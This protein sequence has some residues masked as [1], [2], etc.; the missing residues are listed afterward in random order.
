[1][2]VFPAL[3]KISLSIPFEGGHLPKP[4]SFVQFLMKHQT[5]NHINLFASRCVIR[6]APSHPDYVNWVQNILSSTPKP[7]PQLRG[8]GVALRPLRAP[9]N[10]L[11]EFLRMHPDIETLHLEDRALDTT[12]ISHLFPRFISG[13]IV[14]ILHFQTKV[15]ALTPDLIAYFAF[16]FPNL[17]K[18]KIECS[19][20]LLNAPG[21]H[22]HRTRTKGNDCLDNLSPLLQRRIEEWGL[23]SFFINTSAAVHPLEVWFAAHLPHTEV[24]FFTPGI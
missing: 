6:W 1:M 19:Q 12:Q 8:L 11:T 5:L 15:E 23:R 3:R 18:L 13:P 9:L 14:D 17:R 22:Y 4:S 16:K 2:G 7:F 10:I 21:F 20:I 24:G